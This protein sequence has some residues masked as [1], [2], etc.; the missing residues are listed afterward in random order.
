MLRDFSLENHTDWRYF[1]KRYLFLD[2]FIRVCDLVGLRACNKY[3][4]ESYESSRLMFPVARTVMP[5]EY[6]TAFWT[7][8]LRQDAKFEFN[9][10]HLPFHNCEPTADG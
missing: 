7:H 9:D 4:L 5:S 8:Q 1:G 3:E 2:D 6:A 10:D